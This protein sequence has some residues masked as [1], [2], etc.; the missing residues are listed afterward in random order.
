M[1]YTLGFLGSFLVVAAIVIYTVFTYHGGSIE[2]YLVA[3]TA[4]FS[5]L[6]TTFRFGMIRGDGE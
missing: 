5:S 3:F 2:V 6:A 4:V 1:N